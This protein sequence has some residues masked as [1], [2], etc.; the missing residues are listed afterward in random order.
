MTA[1][2]VLRFL[3][4]HLKYKSLDKFIGTEIPLDI[5]SPDVPAALCD[6]IKEHFNLSIRTLTK[7]NLGGTISKYGLIDLEYIVE[8][9]IPFPSLSGLEIL[10]ENLLVDQENDYSKQEKEASL[11]FLMDLKEDVLENNIYLKIFARVETENN[12]LRTHPNLIR[13]YLKNKGLRIDSQDKILVF[14]VED[15]CLTNFSGIWL[16]KH[17]YL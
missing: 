11:Q 4:N 16:M 6:V 14:T 8:E 15:A 2:S 12:W 5:S 1:F 7:S 17:F 10:K 13:D 9:D 3:S